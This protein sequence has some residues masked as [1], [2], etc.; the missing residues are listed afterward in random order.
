MSLVRILELLVVANALVLVVQSLRV[1]AVYS[2]VYALTKGE[3]RQLPL[4]V[5][6]MALSFMLYVGG[7]SYYLVTIGGPAAVGRIAI[8][9]TAGLL[10]QYGLWNVL[11][12]DRRRYSAVTNFQDL[13]V[14]ELKTAHGTTG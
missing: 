12:F 5:W 6:L 14:D 9:G 2:A 3:R 8:Y 7:T 1:V 4:H 13:S 11:R 10:A